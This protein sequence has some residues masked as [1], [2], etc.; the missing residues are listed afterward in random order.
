MKKSSA[1]EK[2]IINAAID[3]F[4]RKGY[5]ATS[6]QNIT[7]T[8]G[9]TKGA[10][11]THYKSKGDL[12]LRILERF[13]TLCIEQLIKEVSGYPG[14]PYDKIHYC[15]SFISRFAV[16]N[17][18]LCIFLS[19]LTTELKDDENFKKSLQNIYKKYQNFLSKLFSEGIKEGHFTSDMDPDLAALSFMAFQDGILL[20]W[21]LNKDN[22]DGKQFSATF[23][24]IFFT[25]IH[26]KK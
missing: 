16:T 24:K 20:Q 9:L 6:I 25:G 8:V 15:I 26:R 21:N 17:A 1:T 4:V 12:L 5:H 19:S 14:S 7:E 23:R 22:V 13:K 10:F 3:L 18:N 11:Y 2:E